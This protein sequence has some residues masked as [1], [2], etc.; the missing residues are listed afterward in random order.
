MALARAAKSRHLPRPT[1]NL[2]SG[3]KHAGGQV[4]IQ[5]V[6]VVPVAAATIDEGLVATFAVYQAAAD[7]VR[8][9]YGMRTLRADEG[10]L[11]PPAPD[12]EALLADAMDA[13]VDAG[14]TPGSDV[15]LAV[16]VAARV[17][18][19]VRPAQRQAPRRS[20]SRQ[21]ANAPPSSATGTSGCAMSRRVRSSSSPPTA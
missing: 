16:D 21:M 6:L 9:R 17:V 1:I 10:G 13:I 14:L 11:A 2:F 20:C 4:A 3:G 19:V 7:L 18:E 8:D 12:A 15:A 5:D